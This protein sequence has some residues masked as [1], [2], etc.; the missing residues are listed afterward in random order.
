[1]T[2]DRLREIRENHKHSAERTVIQDVSGDRE[3]LTCHECQGPIA[4]NRHDGHGW[5]LL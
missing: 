4:D 5:R 2:D 3:V 1:M